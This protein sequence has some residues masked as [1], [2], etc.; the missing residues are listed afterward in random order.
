MVAADPVERSN[1]DK[2]STARVTEFGVI[3]MLGSVSGRSFDEPPCMLFEPT[4]LCLHKA[5]P[6]RHAPSKDFG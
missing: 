3:S 5:K 4:C 2:A 1:R 6:T